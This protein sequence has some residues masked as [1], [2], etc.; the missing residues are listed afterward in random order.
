MEK[1]RLLNTYVNNVDWTETM[2]GIEGLLAKEEPF[3]IVEVNVDVLL[4]LEQDSYLKKIVR[5]ADMVLVD[6]KPLQW[7]A[8]WQGNPIKEKISGSDLVE[9]LCERAEKKGYSIFILGG[10]TGVA[11]EAAKKTKEKYQGI[12]I[13]GT[14]APLWGFEKNRDEQKKINDLISAVRPDI[15]F[16]CLGCPKQEKWI[17]ENYRICGAKAAFCAGASVDFLAG[18]IKRAPKW[19]SNHGLEWF[20]RFLKEP[21]RLFKRYFIDDMKILGL[22]WRYRGEKG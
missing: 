5:E 18:R 7:I 2:Q 21:R 13:A 12:N 11:Q 4:K 16:V 20:Y 8:K 10:E 3:Y 14:Y 19:M 15:L 9:V 17:Y 22:M 6:G 1:Q